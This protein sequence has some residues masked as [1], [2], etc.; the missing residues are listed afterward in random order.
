MRPGENCNLARS[1]GPREGSPSTSGAGVT[2]ELAFEELLTL[3]QLFEV[4][5]LFLIVR[6]A[7]LVSM[8][9]RAGARG[10]LHVF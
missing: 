2:H 7:R 1:S 6:N 4:L 9:A 8:S 5:P 3:N 10:W